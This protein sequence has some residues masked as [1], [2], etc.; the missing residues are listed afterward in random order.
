[1]SDEWLDFGWSDPFRRDDGQ[2][3]V[4]QGES[5]GWLVVPTDGRPVI[6]QCPCCDKQLPHAK[7][8]RLV[9]DYAYPQGGN[10]K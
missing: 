5:G 7:A 4:K 3:V 10:K 9:A 2:I 1:M 6:S 8:A